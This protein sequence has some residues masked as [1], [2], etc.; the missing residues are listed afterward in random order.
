MLQRSEECEGE[1]ELF[2][3]LLQHRGTT[4]TEKS[5]G[6]EETTGTPEGGCNGIPQ[7]GAPPP[8][9]K[10]K[11]MQGFF[12]CLIPIRVTFC[13]REQSHKRATARL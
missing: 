3:S 13:W 7:W 2:L 10:N 11:N 6:E 5:E 8:M 4:R 1:Q 12:F 9:Y